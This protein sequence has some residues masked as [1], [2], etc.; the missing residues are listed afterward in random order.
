MALD[1]VLKYKIDISC[2]DGCLDVC[3]CV[4]MY[5]CMQVHM[6]AYVC[7]VCMYVC[8]YVCI[9]TY[10]HTR[11]CIYVRMYVCMHACIYTDLR[12][13]VAYLLVDRG[14]SIELKTKRRKVSIV[15]S[16]YIVTYC[17]DT[18]EKTCSGAD[19]SELFYQLKNSLGTA[20]PFNCLGPD[21]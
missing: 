19:F 21:L 9:C 18:I 6:Y 13:R 2:M 10:I 1:L 16:Q 11:V 14:H 17:S 20:Q 3:V 4:C 8:M 12:Q 15:K 7:D 5:V